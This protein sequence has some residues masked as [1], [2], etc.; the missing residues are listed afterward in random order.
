MPNTWM[1]NYD[2]ALYMN[3]PVDSFEEFIS[4]AYYKLSLKRYIKEG[5]DGFI[6]FKYS[7]TYVDYKKIINSLQ[8]ETLKNGINLV[9][10]M[11]LLDYI[12]TREIYIC[13]RYKLGNELKQQDANL[14]ERFNEFKQVVDMNMTRRLRDKQMWDSFFM[15]AM[16]KSGNFSVP[17]SGKTS[18]V[19]GMYAYLKIKEIVNRIV[20]ISPKNAFGSWID[21]FAVC[22][23][24]K[25][26]LNYVNI[27]SQ[28]YHNISERRRAIQYE[29]GNANLIL[30]NYEMIGGLREELISL[31][32]SHTLLVFDEV[33]KVKRID[34]HNAMN[35]LA[36]ARNAIFVVA[37]TGTPIP[38]T[39]AD[40]YN[41]F[42]ILFPDEYND[43]FGFE[44]GML[45][46][47]DLSE[48][49]LINEKLQPFFCRTTKQNLG[50]PQANDD[51]IIEINASRVEN[52]LFDILK[53]KYRKN[54][55]ALMIRILQ[56]ETNPKLLLNTL[57]L[58]EF[59]YILND[60]YNVEEIDYVNYSD[61]VKSLID[62]YGITVKM[63][64]C[65]E[66]ISKLVSEGKTLIIW[67]IFIDSI[68]NLECELS[69]RGLSVKCIYG[70]IPLD[71]RQNLIN[72][73]KSKKF[74]VLIT[75][76]HTLA[77]SVSLHM[78]CHD[79]IYYEYSYNLVHLLQSKDRIHRLGLEDNQYTQY[80]Y[81]ENYYEDDD[82]F[83][84][85]AKIHER[86][87]EKEKIMLDAIDSNILE[88][89]PTSE[90]ELELIFAKIFKKDKCHARH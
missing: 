27:H 24:G 34:G 37:M 50:V 90:E 63:K 46:N 56:L 64:E 44:V 71:D 39:Y 58:S 35:A 2:G 80:Y 14:N 32:D 18:S 19:L 41:F 89:M 22:F 8:R 15:C 75:N 1:L 30:V 70:E 16:Q 6:R 11:E 12:D 17:G 48:M 40:I 85:D 77:E 25:E 33:H 83:S 86:L 42:H 73:F 59:K 87:I 10:S 84:M 65:L 28:I 68:K 79:A 26:I 7:L 38:N 43:F 74:N 21:E 69:K 72:D 81:L 23:E 67:C 49:K 13:S 62:S 36:V 61:E 31:I 78:V 3:V 5:F 53:M 57:D 20:V 55:L 47:P 66:L 29:S 52:K 54:K 60:S 51:I 88:S 9:L 45:K 76:P 82:N 4:S